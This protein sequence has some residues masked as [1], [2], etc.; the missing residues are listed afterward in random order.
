MAT[1]ATCWL[2]DDGNGGA[3]ALVAQYAALRNCE[4]KRCRSTTDLPAGA[5][6]DT[7]IAMPGAKLDDLEVDARA[8][9]AAL[10]RTG[11][12]LYV[13]GIADGSATIAQQ[14]FPWSPVRVAPKQSACAYTFSASP[15]VPCALRG[16][17]ANTL[18]EVCAAEWLPPTAEVHLSV[19]YLDGIERPV[20]FSFRY[21]GGRVLYDLHS[22]WEGSDD[23]IVARLADPQTR[24]AEIGTLIAV[25][26]VS[27]LAEDRPAP[28]NLTIDDR[29]AHY[30]YFNASAV[31]SL[32]RH[33]E[34][35]CP[36]AH[37]DFAWTPCYTHPPRAYID[38]IKRARSGFVW[39]GFV[40]HVDHK[41]IAD[42]ERD[43]ALGVRA[44]G[45]IERRF[46]VRLQPIMIFP[47]ERSV[48]FQLGLLRRRGFLASVE[49]PRHPLADE[50]APRHLSCSLSYRRDEQS[51]FSVL[52]RY[53]ASSLTR[54]RLLAMS[55]IGL[56]IIAYAHPDELGLKRLSPLWNRGPR[57]SHFDEILT[58]AGSKSLPSA[59]LE[60]IARGT[61][62]AL[63]SAA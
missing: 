26:Q 42:P 15:M 25:N 37:T 53:A 29:P 14:P 43:L 58:F 61:T 40:D 19:R 45:E 12:T 52:Y 2:I 18:A 44:V 7:L 22:S 41:R 21:G 13:R 49:E 17:T 33:I 56:P 50:H 16:E 59:S 20:I 34:D 6:R 31:R 39:H 57:S 10:V 63:A 3:Q 38:E 11:A 36:G 5:A 62:T 32:L 8:H 1:A 24:A 46:D 23:P 27:S 54:D 47:F 48:P 28:F 30:D 9:L 4:P 35:L 55:A 60:E 51:G